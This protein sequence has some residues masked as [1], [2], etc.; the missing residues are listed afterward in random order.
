MTPSAV[1]LPNPP[2]FRA[3]RLVPALAGGAALAAGLAWIAVAVQAYFA[4][5]GVFPLIVGSLLGLGIG[6]LLRVLQAGHRGT[7]WLAAALA[8][9]V[10]VA[11][12]HYISYRFEVQ[13][14]AELVRKAQRE[15]PALFRAMGDVG[16]RSFLG[17]LQDEAR[18]GR[19]LAGKV[20]ARGGWAWATWALDALL[21]ALATGAVLLLGLRQPYCDGCGSWIRTT[22]TSTLPAEGSAAL[23]RILELDLPSVPVRYRLRS[24]RAGCG[25]VGLVLE[26]QTSAGR[27]SR[28]SRWLEGESHGKVL[29]IL[30]GRPVSD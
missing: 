13:R 4:P 29:A 19:P 26:W 2:R 18:G 6:G 1:E 16:P 28:A 3:G 20:V 5:L 21:T 15:H 30:D 27:W 8:V 7:A 23:A 12:E 17:Y 11:G 25:P 10:L 9:A 14:Q 24:C 22:R